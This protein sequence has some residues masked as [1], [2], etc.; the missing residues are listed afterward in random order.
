MTDPNFTTFLIKVASDYGLDINQKIDMNDPKTKIT[1]ATLITNIEQGRSL[2]SY[3]QFVKGCAAASG[4]DP[5][6]LDQAL[7]PTSLGFENNS[8][9]SGYVPPTLPSIVRGG[10]SI[11]L[12]F[13][14]YIQAGIGALTS[15]ASGIFGTGGFSIEGISTGGIGGSVTSGFS[16]FFNNNATVP[17][18]V[19]GTYGVSPTISS[20]VSNPIILQYG[21][22]NAP[23]LTVLATQESSGNFNA[24]NFLAV[25]AGAPKNFDLT[26]GSNTIK[27]TIDF[28]TQII[29][30][31]RDAGMG[32]A[33]SGAVGGLQINKTNMIA[34]TKDLD[35]NTPMTAALQVQ[36]GAK[37]ALQANGGKPVTDA[38][39]AQRVGAAW[40]GPGNE[41]AGAYAA[42]TSANWQVQASGANPN[43]VNAVAPKIG[44]LP[45]EIPG[46]RTTFADS[47]GAVIGTSVQIKNSDGSIDRLTIINGVTRDSSGRIVADGQTSSTG[48]WEKA[49]PASA[50]G[51]SKDWDGPVVTGPDGKFISKTFYNPEYNA[52]GTRSYVTIGPT[53]K[54]VEDTTG[55]FT[56][57]GVDAVAATPPPPPLT[58][59]PQAGALGLP[60]T[61]TIRESFYQDGKLISAKYTTADGKEYTLDINGK[62]TNQNG[63]T[64][65]TYTAPANRSGVFSSPLDAPSNQT[66][67]DPNTGTPAVSTPNYN[68]TYVSV[69]S[70]QIDDNDARIAAIEAKIDAGTATTADISVLNEI[71]F[72]NRQ[73][74]GEIQD[75]QNAAI[76]DSQSNLPNANTIDDVQ[77]PNVYGP[78]EPPAPDP[79]V[80]PAGGFTGENYNDVYNVPYDPPSTPN[81][82]YYGDGGGDFFDI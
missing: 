25:Q 22:A 45:N 15:G 23:I 52:D 29:K 12:N 36:L 14:S 80:Q 24:V 67:A 34:L 63:D 21:G 61:G 8:G 77:D 44:S 55:K 26:S 28:Q 16:G 57:I 19:V 62:L 53:G 41:G 72:E 3:D 54:I 46:T 69:L 17:P 40:A 35:P 50:L 20:A 81:D 6:I 11:P 51:L 75:I 56:S 30:L 70:E 49:P 27:S 5:E 37:L 39:G 1:M 43:S 66:P 59:A 47:S 76:V 82:S 32:D 10:S 13:S 33:A 78:P 68:N 18:G 60:S 9:I 58:A 2:Y 65:G 73:L 79:Y 64:I 71:K 7:N 31:Q 42:R 48:V 38:A 4:I 74:Y